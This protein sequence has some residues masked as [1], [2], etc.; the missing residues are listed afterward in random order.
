MHN[1]SLETKSS[2]M[3]W[4]VPISFKSIWYR[5]IIIMEADNSI[6]TNRQFCRFYQLECIISFQMKI[7]Q[8]LIQTEMNSSPNEIIQ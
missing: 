8:I 7:F 2:S 6:Q 4:L 5:D 1:C 3:S